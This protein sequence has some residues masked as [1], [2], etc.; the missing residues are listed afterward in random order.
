MSTK[1]GESSSNGA[2]P[3]QASDKFTYDDVPDVT[4][5]GPV[6]PGRGDRGSAVDAAASQIGEP[7]SELAVQECDEG[8]WSGACVV[9]VNLTEVE[10]TET[11]EKQMVCMA[12]LARDKRSGK[13]TVL[14]GR[15]DAKDKTP[16]DTACRE[17][18]EET[19]GAV[20]LTYK[21]FRDAMQDVSDSGD[22][23]VVTYTA[24]KKPYHCFITPCELSEATLGMFNDRIRE[25]RTTGKIKAFAHLS[26]EELQHYV[27]KDVLVWAPIGHALKDTKNVSWFTRQILKEI[28][29]SFRKRGPHTEGSTPPKEN[30]EK[31]KIDL[32]VR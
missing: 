11:K 8:E 1:S 21:T 28:V 26:E 16:L 23:L 29:V 3:R 17:C 12:M 22:Q 5:H 18:W 25:Y 4:V 15:M 6:E 30:P 13:F 24:T 2:E 27:E 20:E 10:S 31:N 14:G 32:D 9:P 19:C 7:A